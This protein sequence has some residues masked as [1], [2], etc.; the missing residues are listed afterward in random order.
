VQGGDR[1]SCSSS[2]DFCC[3]SRIGDFYR[4]S[5]IGGNCS[6]IG[7]RT[8]CSGFGDGGRCSSGDIEA[9]EVD[10]E[11]ATAGSISVVVYLHET[12]LATASRIVSVVVDVSYAGPQ[13]HGIVNAALHREYSP[14]I[15]FIFFQG[16]ISSNTESNSNEYY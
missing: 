16:R 2:G 6:R 4:F 11:T 5:I 8:S 13:A 9:G 3:S 1:R 15:I 7:D 12:L 14:G 10:A